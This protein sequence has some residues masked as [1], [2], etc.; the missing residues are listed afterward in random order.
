MPNADIQGSRQGSAAMLGSGPWRLPPN[1]YRNRDRNRALTA[2]SDFDAAKAGFRCAKPIYAGSGL[3]IIY[4]SKKD[5][6]R[7]GAKAQSQREEEKKR[8]KWKQ[9]RLGEGIAL[10]GSTHSLSS[11]CAFASCMVLLGAFYI[12]SWAV[13]MWQGNRINQHEYS[14]MLKFWFLSAAQVVR[15]AA[16]PDRFHPSRRASA[17]WPC[18]AWSCRS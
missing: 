7:R 15:T 5:I 13:G 9:R 8:S 1:R 17:C 18:R 6:S 12:C 10:V 14:K 16:C 3:K 2:D 11:L 4:I